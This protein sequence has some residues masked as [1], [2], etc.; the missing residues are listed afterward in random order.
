MPAPCK[1][2]LRESIFIVLIFAEA[3]DCEFLVFRNGPD[4]RGKFRGFQHGG[5]IVSVASVLWH[6]LRFWEAT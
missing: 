4:L 1:V 6:V 5:L 2:A 3:S